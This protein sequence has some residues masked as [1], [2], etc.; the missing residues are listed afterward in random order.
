MPVHEMRC[1]AEG[2]RL[3][4]IPTSETM[5]CLDARNRRY[6]LDCGAKGRKVRLHLR[7]ERGHGGIKSVDLIEMKTK[8]KT[9]VLR[10]PAA[11]GL[12]Q[13]LR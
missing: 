9:M 10:D 11:K 5:T 8:Q 3:M 6:E 12:S 13:F 2:N 7:V 1:A 4:S